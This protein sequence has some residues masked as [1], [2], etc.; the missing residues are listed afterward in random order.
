MTAASRARMRV[1]LA[2][3][4]AAFGAN[5]FLPAA[6]HAQQAEPVER[7]YNH[8]QVAVERALQDMQAYTT[9]RLPVLEGFVSASAGTVQH[10][11]NP[12]YQFRIDVFP[13]GPAQTL[14]QVTAKITA[15]YADADPAHS[16]YV[17]IP[18]NGRLEEDLLD[19]LSLYL[20]KGNPLPPGSTPAAAPRSAGAPADSAAPPIHGSPSASTDSSAAPVRGPGNPDPA[21]LAANIAAVR[22][23]REA[24]ETTQRKLQQQISEL[25]A[26]AGS[27]KYLSNLAVIKAAHTPLF[28]QAAESSTILFHAEPEDEFEVSEVRGAWVHVRLENGGQAWVRGYQLQPP[29]EVDDADDPGAANFPT[30]D[31]D[32]RPFAGNWEPLIAKP[33]LVISV[34]PTRAIP[35]N[36]LGSSQLAFAK[37][38][39]TQGYREATHSTRT[40]AGVV[41]LFL[42]GKAGAAAA[43]VADIRRWRDGAITDKQFL[44]RCSFD[45]PASFRDSL[46]P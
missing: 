10:F 7:V 20:E 8:P 42:G 43:T 41:V 11:E 46:T 39:F 27:Q 26:N 32:V 22:G 16:Q 35:D 21:S 19:R 28:E 36:L 2:A 17:V 15:W 9:A 5:L 30:R 4:L 12:H 38:A 40:I 6:S 23:E 24:V 18:S 44:A 1:T 14:V 31:E 34:Q 37:Y 33:A 3:V 25:E 13:Q 45:P 29:G